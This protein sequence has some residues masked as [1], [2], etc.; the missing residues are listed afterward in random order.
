MSIRAQRFSELQVLVL[1]GGSKDG[2]MEV[3]RAA[4]D[5]VT[6]WVSECDRGIYDAINKGLGRAFGDIVGV[7]GADDVLCD[8]ALNVVYHFWKQR[9]TDIIAGRAIMVDERGGESLREDEDFG[10]G[11][12][13]TGIPFCHNAMF[14]TRR[15]YDAVGLY[16][17]SYR[18]AADAQWSHRAI[19][20][21]LS[22]A[23][24]EHPLV[25]FSL[26][27]RSSTDGDRTMDESYRV[28]SENFPML[29]LS[30]IKALFGDI[31][32]W[33]DTG[34]VESILRRHADA[35]DLHVAVALAFQQRARRLAAAPP[36]LPARAP[37]IGGAIRRALGV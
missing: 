26:G 5:V 20:A 14:A 8:N 30:E 6:D 37:G 28:V 2:T 1:D 17:L 22:C 16:D 10:P 21:G 27:G 29:D 33:T 24:I 4:D 15:A 3:V 9:P 7:V 32:G 25:R 12:L 19:R 35:I 31:R 18:L 13:L 34:E 11:A 36:P 23:R